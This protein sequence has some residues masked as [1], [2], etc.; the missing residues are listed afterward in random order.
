MHANRYTAF[1]DACSLAGA[2]HR[3]VLL[4]LAEAELYRPRWSSEVME[5]TERAIQRILADQPDPEGS[6]KKAAANMKKAFPEADVG[7]VTAMLPMVPDLPDAGDRHVV[8]GVIIARAHVLVT[9]NIKDFPE[10]VL[11]VFDTEV[12]TTD[13]FIANTI[14]LDDATALSAIRRMRKRLKKPSMSGDKLLDLM[15]LRGLVSSA[16][17]LRPFADFI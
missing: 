17:L 7:D 9:D 5:E 6:A 1:V 16:G 12:K 11:S 15:E 3:N 8:A 10:T 4:S 13:E 2:L 14:D